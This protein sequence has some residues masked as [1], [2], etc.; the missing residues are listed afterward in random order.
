LPT[1]QSPCLFAAA[2]LGDK[3]GSVRIDTFPINSM[4][5]PESELLLD[6][7]VATSFRLLFTG[8]DKFQQT[9]GFSYTGV[10]W[11]NRSFN[12]DGSVAN[13]SQ[14]GWDLANNRGL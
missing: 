3:I 11:T 13:V 1:A 12:P 6:G 8:S 5:I 10:S 4:P 2:A 14:G 7:P 9:L